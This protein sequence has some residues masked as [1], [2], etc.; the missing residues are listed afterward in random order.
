MKRDKGRVLLLFTGGTIAMK[1]GLDDSLDVGEMLIEEHPEFANIVESVQDRALVDI[2]FLFN[3]D[4]TNVDIECWQKIGKT[5]YDNYDDYDGF[6]VS[7]GTDTLAYSSSAISFMLQGIGKPVVF[8]GAQLSLKNVYTDGTNNLIN[9]ILLAANY[10]I[11]EVCILFGTQIIRGTRGRKISAFDLQAFTSVNS[12]PLGTIGLFFKL[13]KNV[14]W[15]KDILGINYRDEFDSNVAYIKVHPGLDSKMFRNMIRDAHGVIIAG[16]GAG[17]V[18]EKLLPDIHQI[19]EKDIPVVVCTQCLVGKIELKL[20]KVG[21]SL[22]KIGII[23]AYDMTPEAAT[24]KL[25]WCL[26]Q[27]DNLDV[28]RSYF[29]RDLVGELS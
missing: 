20:Y 14:M 16:Y 6:V 23:S 15:R 12:E 24:V 10:D 28:I 13:S 2:E 3:I 8:T 18:P 22:E 4:S 1:K 5:I 26:G 17:N 11:G 25:M 7:H 9:S 29:S 19:V 27:T 21:S